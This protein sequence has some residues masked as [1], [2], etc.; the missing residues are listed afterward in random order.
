MIVFFIF[1]TFFIFTTINCRKVQFL[2]MGGKVKRKFVPIKVKLEALKRLESSESLIKL[3][4]EYGV[5]EV[6]VED[7][8]WNKGIIEMFSSVK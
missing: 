8:C 4:V 7:W 3:A 2:T 1:I 6:T 5:G